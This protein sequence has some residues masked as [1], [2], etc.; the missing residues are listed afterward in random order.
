MAAL[1]ALSLKLRGEIPYVWNLTRAALRLMTDYLPLLNIEKNVERLSEARACFFLGD[2]L[3][4]IRL[5]SMKTFFVGFF[6]S[7]IY[8]NLVF[9]VL[10]S[11]ANF[12]KS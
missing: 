6:S 7:F 4:D 9:S 2:G 11:S 3:M 8:Y 10:K 1:V 5:K 12:L